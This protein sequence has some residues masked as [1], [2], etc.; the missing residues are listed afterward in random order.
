MMVRGDLESQLSDTHTRDGF[1]A[2]DNG[3]HV[4]SRI[5]L[6]RSG[7]LILRWMRLGIPFGAKSIGKVKCNYDP[8]L[9]WIN[10]IQK[11]K[12]VYLQ[13]ATHRQH[14]SDN[15]VTFIGAHAFDINWEKLVGYV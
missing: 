12:I 8:N 1:S 6:A 15:Y 10:K 5:A 11:K 4:R 2:P 9:V 3:C 13:P 14:I 7:E